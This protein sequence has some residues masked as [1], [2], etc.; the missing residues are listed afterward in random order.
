MMACVVS[1]M[2][3]P[4]QLLQ[5]SQLLKLVSLK[6]M[7]EYSFICIA[8]VLGRSELRKKISTFQAKVQTIKKLFKFCLLIRIFSFPL[9]KNEKLKNDF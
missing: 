7:L 6:Y 3:F 4:K 2:V 5:T 9:F 8:I 1:V